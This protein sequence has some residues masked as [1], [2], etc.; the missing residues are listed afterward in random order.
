MNEEELDKYIERFPIRFREYLKRENK[1]QSF[2]ENLKTEF[3]TIKVYRAIHCLKELHEND[4]LNNIDE[5]EYF[6]PGTKATEELK[7]FAISVNESREVICA[8]FKFPCKRRHLVGIAV[9]E[10]KAE[11]G[12][13]DFED[14]RTHHNWYLYEGYS[15]KLVNEFKLESRE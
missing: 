13:A 3:S 11:Y 10:M 8:A 4:F 6:H 7:N 14:D 15:K 9:G 1:K 5:K 2:M 12:P